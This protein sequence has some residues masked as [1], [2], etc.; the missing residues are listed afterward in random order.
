MRYMFAY[1]FALD[2]L[3]IN[4]FNTSNVTNFDAMFSSTHLSSIDL[5]NINMSNATSVDYMMYNMTSLK[6]LKTPNTYS[7]D[8]TKTITL[9][10]TLYDASG[11]SYTTLD[12][13]SPT[14]TWLKTEYVPYS[15]TYDLDGGT[16]SNAN[17]TA[18][19][20]NSNSITLNNPTKEG[21]RFVGWSGGKNLF[22]EET[23]LMNI[24]NATYENE[25]YNFRNIDAYNKYHT[26][27]IPIL[28]DYKLNTEYTFKISGYTES[29]NLSIWV[30]Y[31]NGDSSNI[32]WLGSEEKTFIFKTAANKTI[33]YI[34]FSFGSTA[35]VHISSFQLEEG[36][37]A[38]DYEP[39]ISEE[40]TVTIPTGSEGNRTYTAI[41]EEVVEENESND[42]SE[43]KIQA[44]ISNLISSSLGML[45]LSFLSLFASLVAAN[46]KRR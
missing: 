42:N 8:T 14:S 9:P 40:T 39:Y 13:N 23:I 29:S 7:S 34:S 38:T 4:N 30:Y 44:N 5:S 21:Y 2:Y 24:P 18:Y 16:V 10:T 46:E 45:E 3:N 6:Q 35:M 17:Q 27:G 22:D 37:S 43:E 11:N 33:D 25:Y 32:G 28:T 12:N 20:I 1:T 19:N 26:S 36:S 15:I 31:T 41:W